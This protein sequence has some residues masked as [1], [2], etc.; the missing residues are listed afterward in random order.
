L[1]GQKSDLDLNL[2]DLNLIDQKLTDLKLTDLNLADLGK[3]AAEQTRLYGPASKLFWIAARS[4][5]KADGQLPHI[6]LLKQQS[7]QP[8]IAFLD[9]LER[10][11][12]PARQTQGLAD[13]P[14]ALFLAE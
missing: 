10:G 3:R 9:Q 4:A 13:H 1:N 8:L 7:R 5:V 11:V 6:T 2:I 14:V 12:F